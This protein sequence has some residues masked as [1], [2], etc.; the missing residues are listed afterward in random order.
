[1]I[2]EPINTR[3]ADGLDARNDPIGSQKNGSINEF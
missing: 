2:S 3:I 1:M